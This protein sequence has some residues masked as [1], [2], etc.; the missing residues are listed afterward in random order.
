MAPPLPTPSGASLPPSVVLSPAEVLAPKQE[1]QA[2]V[3][4]NGHPSAPGWS[5]ARAQGRQLVGPAS[6]AWGPVTSGVGQVQTGNGSCGGP[7][8]GA[9][10]GQRAGRKEAGW[11]RSRLLYWVGPD[12][13]HR[14]PW[15]WS[16]PPPSQCLSHSLWGPVFQVQDYLGGGAHRFHPQEGPGRAAGESQSAC[17]PLPIRPGRPEGG[18]VAL[19]FLGPSF[20]GNLSPLPQGRSA[21]L[22]EA[23]RPL[24]PWTQLRYLPGA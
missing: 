19:P 5:G 2:R 3:S 12:A 9:G 18:G 16:E 20:L 14:G 7:V 17:C 10:G 8:P 24:S 15:G 22:Q 21:F 23:Q 6:W 13:G 1:V 4:V 11:K